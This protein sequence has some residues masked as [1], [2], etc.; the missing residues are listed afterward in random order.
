MCSLVF[1]SHQEEDLSA[2]CWAVISP[3][4]LLLV[5]GGKHPQAYLFPESESLC[6]QVHR[7]LVLISCQL[8]YYDSMI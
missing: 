8:K 4:E 2:P 7:V 6:A 5:L 1:K 3:V